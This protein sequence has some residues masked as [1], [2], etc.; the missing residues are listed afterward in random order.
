VRG[1]SWWLVAAVLLVGTPALGHRLA[2]SYL[3]L[4]ESDAG[5]VE[6]LW[7]TPLLRARG[8]DLRPVLPIHCEAAAAPRISED[9]TA[10]TVRLQLDC[11]P[12][13][14]AG[15]T[16]AA[17]G[18]AESGTDVLVH[19]VL[20]DGNALRLLLSRARPEAR[21]PGREQAGDVLARYG[22]L[23]VEHLFTGLDHALFVTGLV[24]LVS[25]RRRLI[26]AITAF[27]LG[28]SAT[29]AL[30]ALGV[31][32]IPTATAELAIAASLVLLARALLAAPGGPPSLLARRPWLA[33]GGFGLVHGLGFAGALAEIGLPTGAIPLAL[34]A[35]NVGIEV[36]QL[37]LVGALLLAG[38]VLASMARS[39]G[40]LAAEL[41]A[42][43][44]G[45]LGVFF[46]LERILEIAVAP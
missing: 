38:T 20:A 22:A 11:G 16:L 9:A 29:L 17:D 23:G 12:H 2:P 15:A 4:R 30:A 14:L 44:I 42:T 21:I 7:R 25:G 19:A 45:A 40:R 3:E 13:G 28:H 36:G 43:A 31:L 41:P 24:L 32:R 46:L 35:F 18:L 27:T 26:G 6:V 33:S 1:A 8:S 5:R 34:F 10:R 39:G 37:A